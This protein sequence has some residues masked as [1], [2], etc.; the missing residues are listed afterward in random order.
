MNERAWS[1]ETPTQPGAYWCR[2]DGRPGDPVVVQVVQSA[3]GR[4]KVL[5]GL[6]LSS[7]SPCE[8]LGPL[9]QPAP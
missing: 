7:L 5:Y 1:K 3:E 6:W 4:L 9:Q 2:P 8:W